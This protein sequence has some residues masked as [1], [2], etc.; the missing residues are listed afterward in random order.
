MSISWIAI[1]IGAVLAFAW[2]ALVGV[3]PFERGVQVY[4]YALIMAI[5][6]WFAG[7]EW[8]R[9]PSTALPIGRLAAYGV[10]MAVLWHAAWFSWYF[11]H[12][13]AD[14]W[15]LLFF[16]AMVL[17]TIDILSGRLQRPAIAIVVIL[18]VLAGAYFSVYS[19]GLVAL[20]FLIPVVLLPL[21]MP[22]T[23][24]IDESVGVLTIVFIMAAV[25]YA[26]SLLSVVPLVAGM[27]VAY[28]WGILTEA[29]VS[30]E[31]TRV[32]RRVLIGLALSAGLLFASPWI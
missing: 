15:I 23:G 30:V 13:G 8:W 17:W 2:A 28:W 16:A 32:W 1:R 4:V 10:G 22:W 11:N 29:L 27:I 9:K 20:F 7:R 19:W 24:W 26:L 21:C 3:L 25:A 31:P 12:Y 14:T 5:I 18:S 6:L